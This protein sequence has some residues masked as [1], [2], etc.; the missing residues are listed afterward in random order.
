[1][2]R[3]K[4]KGSYSAP[5]SKKSWQDLSEI[6]WNIFKEKGYFSTLDSRKSWEDLSKIPWNVSIKKWYFQ[7]FRFKEEMTGFNENSAKF[8]K[9]KLSF[10]SILKKKKKWILEL[11]K[12]QGISKMLVWLQDMSKL[13]IEDFRSFRFRVQKKFWVK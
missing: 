13:V 12:V 1:M 5:G 8:V 10:H 11:L 4:E 9:E 2:I 6:P 7:D 3:N